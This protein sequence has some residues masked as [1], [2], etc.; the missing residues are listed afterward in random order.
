MLDRL[1]QKLIAAGRRI[2]PDQRVPH[3]FE[4]RILAILRSPA[5]VDPWQAWSR[6]LWRAAALCVAITTLSGVCAFWDARTNTEPMDLERAVLAVVDHP[7]D[8]W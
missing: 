2:Q 5:P 3:A 4:Q 1:E 7:G 6:V 8:A